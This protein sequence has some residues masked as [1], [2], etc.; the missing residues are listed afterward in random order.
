M[1]LVGFRIYD[2]RFGVLHL[3]LLGLGFCDLVCSVYG[4]GISILGSR[5][6]RFGVWHDDLG[7]MI[8]G[9]RVMCF[10]FRVFCFKL[11]L[12]VFRV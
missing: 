2:F 1:R 9:F 11:R 12:L 3:G 4:L 10:L 5:I 8:L 6:L 7:F